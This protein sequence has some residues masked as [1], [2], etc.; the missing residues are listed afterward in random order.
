MRCE[1]LEYIAVI[2]TTRTVEPEVNAEEKTYQ[3]G[4]LE[5]DVVV[6]DLDSKKSIGGF[7][8]KVNNGEKVANWQQGGGLDVAKELRM[9][10]EKNIIEQF[11]TLGAK[12]KSPG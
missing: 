12:V 6:F 4:V 8:F 7:P 10:L 9:Q 3:S 5:G 2:R 11:E 1:K